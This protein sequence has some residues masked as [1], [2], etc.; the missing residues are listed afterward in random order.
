M[1]GDNVKPRGDAICGYGSG[2]DSE[3]VIMQ[4]SKS[5]VPSNKDPGQTGPLVDESGFDTM[6]PS[7]GYRAEAD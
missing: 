1:R 7:A 6:V 4:S 5:T 2:W 3:E